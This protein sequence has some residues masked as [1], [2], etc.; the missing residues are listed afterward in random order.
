MGG[1]H[2]TFNA[3]RMR[4]R[5]EDV[6]IFGARQSEANAL[7]PEDTQMDFLAVGEADESWPAFLN[8]VAGGDSP[9]AIPG[10]VTRTNRQP[11]GT[12]PIGRR[13]A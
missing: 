1:P 12:V 5:G 9:D 8:A 10:I 4:L 2:P 13:T 6:E 3:A 11:D 7:P